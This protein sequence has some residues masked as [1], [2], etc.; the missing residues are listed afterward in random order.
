MRSFQVREFEG[1][2]STPAR[3]INK[4]KIKRMRVIKNATRS[5]NN[6]TAIKFFFVDAY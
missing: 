4:R 6:I 1:N 3:K 5:E 2:S